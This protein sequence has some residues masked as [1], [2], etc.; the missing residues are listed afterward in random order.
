MR[1]EEVAGVGRVPSA[2]KVESNSQ[3]LR[4]TWR[5][6]ILA[7]RMAS[8]R[9][10][11]DMISAVGWGPFFLVSSQ[12]GRSWILCGEQDR[13]K[14]RKIKD[15]T[16]ARSLPRHWSPS[17]SILVPLGWKGKRALLVAGEDGMR[18]H[19]GTCLHLR[20]CALAMQIAK[21]D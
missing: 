4:T 10:S 16:S 5:T 21:V 9:F 18:C 6:K 11:S 13:E 3:S 19:R 20:V 2:Y 14:K 8:S 1:V 12:C 17:P 15:I 7:S